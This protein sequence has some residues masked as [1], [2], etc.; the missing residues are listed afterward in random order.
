[1]KLNIW[2]SQSEIEKTYKVDKYDIMYGTVEDIL[3]V[4]EEAGDGATEEDLTMAV[5][6]HREM[7]NRFLKDIFDG[8]TDEELRRTKVKEIAPLMFELFDYARNSLA[9]K[10]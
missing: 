5:V 6:K 2:K 3:Q 1:M 4:I 9:S 10:N 7:F 8:L